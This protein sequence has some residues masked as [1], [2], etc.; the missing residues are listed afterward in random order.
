MKNFYKMIV[1][2]YGWKWS[3]LLCYSVFLDPVV[4]LNVLT[5][6]DYDVKLVETRTVH[7][8]CFITCLPVEKS[9][10]IQSILKGVQRWRV[11]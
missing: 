10:D 7:F 11:S 9:P 2:N 4:T 1:A 5:A 8:V 6:S 3:L